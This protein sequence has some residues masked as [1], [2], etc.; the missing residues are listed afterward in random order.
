M[1]LAL[2][3]NFP[4]LSKSESRKDSSCKLPSFPF[5][6]MYLKLKFVRSELMNKKVVFAQGL[7]FFKRQLSTNIPSCK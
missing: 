1:I 5:G 6:L 3:D 7:D 2:S 4:L